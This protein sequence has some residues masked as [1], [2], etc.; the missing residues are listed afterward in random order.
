METSNHAYKSNKPHASNWLR[1]C[2]M[3]N[4]CGLSLAKLPPQSDLKPGYD[5]TGRGELVAEADLVYPSVARLSWL[6]TVLSPQSCRCNRWGYEN[7]RTCRVLKTRPLWPTYV[8]LKDV[9]VP[10]R[11]KLLRSYELG[12]LW[13]LPHIMV[14]LSI[15]SIISDSNCKRIK[16]I[17]SILLHPD[18]GHF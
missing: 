18:F 9:A 13:T 8:S 17:F 1:P 10:E 2:L 11:P 5:G 7:N 6:S 16:Q 15:F 4:A 14:E 3:V 12:F